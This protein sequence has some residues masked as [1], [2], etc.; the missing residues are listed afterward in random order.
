MRKIFK[1]LFLI[2]ICWFSL[3]LLLGCSQRE[4]EIAFFIY[5]D[6]DTFIAELMNYLTPN[7]PGNIAFE[8]HVAGKSQ[9]VQNQQIVE[10]IEAGADLLVINAVDRLASSAIVARSAK[11]NVPVIFFNREPLEGV[12]ASTEN[13][14]YVGI[15]AIGMGRRQADM[16]A[17]LFTENFAGSGFDRN[18]DGIIQI[19]VLKGERGHQDA[20]RRTDN[21]IARI[22]ELGFEVELLAIE[23][24]DWNRSDGFDAMRRLYERYGDIIELV[25]SNNDDMA[26]GAIDFLLDAEIFSEG[27]SACEQPFII[28]GVD[29]TT[30]GLEAIER[31]LLYGTVN[32]D[33]V[34]QANAILALIDFILNDRDFDEFPYELM[35]D[36][37]ILFDSDII[38]EENLTEFIR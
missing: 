6:D 29:G 12:I 22:M 33:A 38:T 36:R 28:V 9:S 2:G 25:F 4:E 7:M 27:L 19:V 23:V 5:T 8:V 35:H 15:D 31:G 14:F 21:S 26:L 18:N 11:D 10:R 16:V 1:R 34:A 30:V 37:Y 24:A 32:N 13:I 17:D 20:E 3:L